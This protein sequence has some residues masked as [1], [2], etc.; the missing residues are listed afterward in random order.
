[1]L[2]WFVLASAIVNIV[3]SAI[4][5]TPNLLSSMFFKVLPA[6]AGLGSLIYFMQTMGWI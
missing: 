4:V 3:W 6:F 1:M 2:I 5:E